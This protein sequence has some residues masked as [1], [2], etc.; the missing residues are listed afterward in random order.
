MIDRLVVALLHGYKRFVSPVLPPACRFH[1]TCSEYAVEAVSQHGAFRG[2][3]LA[4]GR[5]AR[6]HPWS[7]G[8]FDPVPPP[9]TPARPRRG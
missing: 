3:L 6:C 1:P 9:A 7:R 8:G 2:G 4:I 5:L